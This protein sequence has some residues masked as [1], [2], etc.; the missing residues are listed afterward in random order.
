[1]DYKDIIAIIV[2]LLFI[3][4]GEK[5]F[6]QNPISTMINYAKNLFTNIKSKK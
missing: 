6:P 3:L 4:V 1:M 2:V 5:I